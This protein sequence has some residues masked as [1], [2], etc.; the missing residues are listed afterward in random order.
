M[1]SV[2]DLSTRSAYPPR[3]VADRT[4]E[5]TAREFVSTWAGAAGRAPAVLTEDAREDLSELD[6]S[7]RIPVL[8]ALRKLRTEPEQRGAA[9]GSKATSNLTMFRKLVVGNGDYRIVYRIEADGP[10]VV[11]W[12]I[13]RRAD[14]EVYQFAVSRLQLHPDV[15]VRKL[16]ETLNEIWR[17]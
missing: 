12:V 3:Q 11:V 17:R 15:A 4:V 10:V 16:S 8:K 9:L 7:A 5:L 13:A 1:L 2:R 6:G 14:D